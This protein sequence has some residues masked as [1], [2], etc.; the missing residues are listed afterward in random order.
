MM[1]GN[2]PPESQNI[3]GNWG[4]QEMR[5]SYYAYAALDRTAVLAMGGTERGQHHNPTWNRI[6]PP[7]ELID[8]VLPASSVPLDNLNVPDLI[9]SE[10]VP[11]LITSE[12]VPD[13]ITSENVP[14]LI[15]SENVP[16]LITSE[17]VP[18]LITSDD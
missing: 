10:N 5:N 18:D 14:G 4:S 8:F 13:L 1:D 12:N 2:V 11:D 9:T 7:M 15:T 16:D 3:L 17:N 6:R